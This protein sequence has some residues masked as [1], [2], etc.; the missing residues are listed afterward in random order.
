MYVYRHWTYQSVN[1]E[2]LA[3]QV[4]RRKDGKRF[5]LKFTVDYDKMDRPPE[6]HLRPAYTHAI[7]VLSKRRRKERAVIPSTDAAPTAPATANTTQPLASAATTPS[8]S[9]STAEL[10]SLAKQIREIRETQLQMLQLVLQMR[11][12]QATP[13]AQA[14]AVQRTLRPTHHP[15]QAF[16]YTAVARPS[17]NRGEGDGAL[18][19]ATTTD[20][21]DTMAT[22]QSKRRRTRRSSSRGSSSAA[23]A[24]SAVVSTAS[25]ALS[26]ASRSVVSLPATAY[27][28]VPSSL[29]PGTLQSVATVS[30]QQTETMAAPPSALAS[31]PALSSPGL[32]I[33][34]SEE[35]M[36]TAGDQS[37]G[38]FSAMAGVDGLSSPLPSSL[39]LIPNFICNSGT[40]YGLST[41]LNSAGLVG[42]ELFQRAAS[43]CQAP[44]SVPMQSPHGT[45]RD[46]ASLLQL[47]HNV[48]GE[49]SQPRQRPQHRPAGDGGV[50]PT[51]TNT[52]A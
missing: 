42:S 14:A 19:A 22:R 39:Q 33:H 52:S 27:T 6:D 9:S 41:Q 51:T 35:A 37:H 25:A 4:S 47:Q 49:L 11:S 30:G 13:V 17:V 34:T 29:A 15:P 38:G 23:T 43:T 36:L 18:S 3:P 10:A 50:S 24:T 1:W 40:L 12:A 20:N 31:L 48:S 46:A 7:E 16:G 21:A 45:L 28:V 44:E 32:F 8:V 5:M 2:L 26:S